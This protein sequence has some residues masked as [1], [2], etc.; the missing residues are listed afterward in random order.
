[1]IAAKK[2]QAIAPSDEETIAAG[3]TA[4]QSVIDR[5]VDALKASRDG[6]S[7][8]REVLRQMTMKGS[9]CVCRVANYLLELERKERGR[10]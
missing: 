10:Q 4:A 8:P 1:M 9:G 5:H 7:T 2:H 3:V 6:A